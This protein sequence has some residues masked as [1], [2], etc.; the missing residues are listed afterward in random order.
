MLSSL[1]RGRD[2]PGVV[3]TAGHAELELGLL[4]PEAR[5]EFIPQCRQDAKGEAGSQ[6]IMSDGW[7]NMQISIY[8]HSVGTTK[9]SLTFF[10]C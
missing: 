6:M 1:P 8:L 10:F 3:S 5:H 4:E 2:I 7:L 9:Q